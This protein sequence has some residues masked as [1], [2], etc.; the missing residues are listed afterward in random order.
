METPKQN[1][2]S[3]TNRG[4][5]IGAAAAG[6]LVV[7]VLIIAVIAWLGN[8]PNAESSLPESLKPVLVNITLPLNG[9]VQALGEPA[10]V[11][12]EAAG[13]LP[14]KSMELT[15][16]GMPFTNQVSSS[17]AGR[18]RMGVVWAWTPNKEG[19][20]TLIA[21]A[22]VSD[23]RGGVSK[24]V[25]L[26][27][28]AADK[29]PAVTPAETSAATPDVNDI[30]SQ[31]DAMQN[32]TPEAP[33]PGY[34]GQGEFIDPPSPPE[35]EANP[36]PQEPPQQPGSNNLP[37]DLVLI[38]Q[39]WIKKI[40]PINP[41]LAP[42]L[43]GG[44]DECTG[45]LLVKDKSGDEAGFFLYR[46]DPLEFSFKRIATI[47]GKQGQGGLFSY[48][49]PGLASGNYT[50]YISAF[51]AA[52][53]TDSELVTIHIT[54]DQ[55]AGAIAEPEFGP[56]SIPINIEQ[57]V[58][59]AY[60][61]GSAEGMPWVRLPPAPETFMEKVNGK[62]DLAPY[63]KMI[64]LPKPMPDKITL[65]MECWGWSGSTLT[66]L[67]SSST[68]VLNIDPNTLK[69]LGQLDLHGIPGSNQQFLEAPA[70]LPAPYNL[71]F[72]QKPSQCKEYYSDPT[73]AYQMCNKALKSGEMVL[74]WDWVPG[75]NLTA[76]QLTHVKFAVYMILPPAVQSTIIDKTAV[77]KKLY[78]FTPM[79]GKWVYSE[80]EYFVR[81][82]Y[83]DGKEEKYSADSNHVSVEEHLMTVVGTKSQIQMELYMARGR[84]GLEDQ[85][86]YWTNS[87]N[88]PNYYYAGHRFANTGW[89][90]EFWYQG[91]IRLTFDEPIFDQINGNIYKAQLIWNKAKP[92]D[93]SSAWFPCADVVDGQPVPVANNKW[94]A[95]VTA[96]VRMWKYGGMQPIII[97][98]R[99]K[100]L[101][102]VPEHTVDQC[103]FYYNDFHLE[104]YTI[105]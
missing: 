22:V 5:A 46:M 30:V 53:E 19:E 81:A 50:Y 66:Y 52:G 68:V 102:S 24:A 84:P 34:N 37:S 18:E 29:M 21:R 98:N 4:C 88:K 3:R 100:D 25:R 86:P 79:Y 93:V 101:D 1:N 45:I 38:G 89:T 44:A 76:E 2:I 40:V 42:G 58:E 8:L 47:D 60:C 63:W 36:L 67:G 56:D 33:P 28:L 27:V 7:L 82:Y 77:D 6:G 69:Q 11:Y 10:R 74:V 75:K 26:N 62:Y 104:V 70:L 12:V 87:T 51:N 91:A 41:P 17:P 94:G 90:G 80:P 78:G 92:N 61:Y 31:A 72:V 105:D 43:S 85:G 57:P 97:L 13:E 16:N 64:P 23:G 96:Q 73:Q 103:V 65:H 14:I 99:R 55:C 59:K 71:K 48:H 95:D 54:D 15:I 35:E 49:D 9:A 39:N 83:N 20:Y 32:V